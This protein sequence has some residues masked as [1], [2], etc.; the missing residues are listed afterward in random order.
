[1]NIASPPHADCDPPARAPSRAAQRLPAGTC[2]A[3]LH[4]F[5]PHARYPLDARRNY[6]PHACGLDDYR[7]VMQ[8]IGVDRA[9][10]VQ[11]SVYG[12]DNSAMLDALHAGGAAFRGVAVPAPDTDDDALKHMHALGVRGIRLNL[13]NPQVVGAGEVLTLLERLKKLGLPWHMQL[14]ADL[15][16][17]PDA[18]LSLCDKTDAP[19]V[20]DH[21]GKLPPSVRA[22]PLFDLLKSGRCWVKLSAPYRVSAQPP[23]HGDITNLARALADANPARAVWGTDWPHTELHNG[24]PA[25]ASLADLLHAWLPDPATLRHICVTNPARLYEFPQEKTA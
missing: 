5:G 2:D 7:Q 13:V 22:H 9:V 4:V 25:A 6:T 15:A 11:P 12:T 17:D 8:A 21:M 1:M 20:V 16:H 18:L 14:L 23:P 19:I 10:L 3:H 24:T